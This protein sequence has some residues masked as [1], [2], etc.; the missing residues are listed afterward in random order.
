MKKILI[1]DSHSIMRKGIKQILREE[2]TEVEFDEITDL[3]DLFTKIKKGKWDI[4]I[5]DVN[6]FGKNGLETVKQLKDRGINVP[7]LALSAHSEKHFAIR[8]FKSGVSGYLA[9]DASDRELVKAVNQILAG[10]KYVTQNVAEQ[11]TEEIKNGY[12]KA[13]HEL[14]SDR[15]LQILLL[16]ATGK[17][18]SQIAGQLSLSVTTISTYRARILE[19]MKM[20]TSAELTSYAIRNELV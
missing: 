11:I 1:A 12:Q 5:L 18:V 4:L 20:K 14:L 3:K 17:T 6:M 9:K 15:E 8:A 10:R 16:I 19:K 13:P 2:N 7:I